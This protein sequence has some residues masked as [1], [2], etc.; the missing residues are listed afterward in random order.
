MRRTESK[1]VCERESW[2]R[3]EEDRKRERVGSVMRRA[4][5]RVSER[6]LVPHG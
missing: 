6:E 1:S 3:T 5:E 4:A 2:F